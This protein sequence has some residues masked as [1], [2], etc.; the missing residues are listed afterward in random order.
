MNIEQWDI[1]ELALPGP[2]GGNP[3]ADVQFGATFQ[4]QHRSIPVDGFYDGEGIF[5]ARFMPETPGTWQYVTHSNI[6]ELDGRTGEFTCVPATGDNH[7]PVRVANLYHFAYADGTPHYSIGTTCYVWT[8]QPTALQERTLDTLAKAPFNKMRMCVFPKHYRFNE[9]EPDLYP[10]ERKTDGAWDF[11]R[12]NPAFFRQFE[13]RVADLRRLGIEADI[14]LF[15]P[16]DRWGF[17]DMTLEE[18]LRYLRYF[19]ARMAA[20]R[21]VWWSLANEYDLMKKSV[22]DWDVLFQCVQER[23]PYQHLRSIHNWQLLN[24]HDS[25]KFY[26]H[27]KPWVTHASIQQGHLD[28][29]GMWRAQYKKP[30]VVDECCYEGDIPNGWGNISARELVHRFWE[31]TVRGGYVGHGE[32]YLS[33]GDV[34]WWS[35]GGVLRGESPSRIAFLRHI[36]EVYG[37][38]E[39]V[40]IANERWFAQGGKA[41]EYYLLYTHVHQP[42]V[43]ELNLPAGMGFKTEVIDTWEMT[44]TPLDGIYEGRCDVAMPG[45]PYHAL[46]LRKV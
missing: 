5:R 35:K 43:I 39:P 36:L 11:M 38:I 25:Q 20:H 44:V 16:Y 14:I 30:V 45:K 29:V 28:L 31:G 1:F 22:S 41:G 40:Q 15:H 24:A 33:G 17:A 10:F 13:G 26:D 8:H 4:Y 23:D 46:R 34:L 6:P 42:S 32:T 21:N 3:F 7:G 12:F 37:P 19:I 27:G 18:D 9:N 2:S